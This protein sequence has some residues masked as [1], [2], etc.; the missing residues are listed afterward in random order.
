[1]SSTKYSKDLLMNFVN[2]LPCQFNLD[3]FLSGKLLTTD[4]ASR[5]L[6]SVAV[7]TSVNYQNEMVKAKRFLNNEADTFIGINVVSIKSDQSVE[8]TTTLMIIRFVNIVYKARMPI[9]INDNVVFL[10]TALKSFDVKEVHAYIQACMRS[11]KHVTS[12]KAQ[13]VLDKVVPVT[14]GAELV[15]VYDVTPARKLNIYNKEQVTV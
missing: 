11:D 2:Q 6:R 15:K 4:Q 5:I 7:D 9:L 10:P 1:M 12:V 14:A 3:Y 13:T 8:D